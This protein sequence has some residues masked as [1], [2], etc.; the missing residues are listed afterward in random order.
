MHSPLDAL[1]T[2]ADD[3]DGKGDDDNDDEGDDDVDDD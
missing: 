3:D 2:R 1:P